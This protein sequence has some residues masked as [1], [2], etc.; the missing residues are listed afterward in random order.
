MSDVEGEGFLDFVERE[1]EEDATKV[2]G[3]PSMAIASFKKDD[4]PKQ[5]NSYQEE[6]LADW[7]D[8]EPGETR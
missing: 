8:R 4:I 6:T 2:A 7:N 3:T 1:V 5:D